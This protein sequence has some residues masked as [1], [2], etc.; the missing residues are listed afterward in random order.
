MGY[1]LTHGY[2]LVHTFYVTF[3]STLSICIFDVSPVIK[4]LYERRMQHNY[5]DSHNNLDLGQ[6]KIQNRVLFILEIL[7]LFRPFYEHFIK[8]QYV[9][10][11]NCLTLVWVYL[12]LPQ[13]VAPDSRCN[14]IVAT[15][16]NDNIFLT[17]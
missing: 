4:I 16:C 11:F 13:L 8:L 1:L 9:L 3:I 17:V 2:I 15:F 7:W 14:K 12:T 5:N 6:N 10:S